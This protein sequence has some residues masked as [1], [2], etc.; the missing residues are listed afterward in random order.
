MKIKAFH[1]YLV[2]IFISLSVIATSIYYL[3]DGFDEI[4]VYELEGENRIV[5]GKHFIGKST[6]RTINKYFTESRKLI[7]DSAIIGTL[8]IV[9]NSNDSIQSNEVDYFV[10]I[11]IAGEMAEVPLG[12]QVRE[13]QCSKKLAVFLS[14][15]PWVRP[16]PRKINEL[17]DEKAVETK[18]VLTN[19]SFE[20]HYHDDS[21]SV[22]AWIY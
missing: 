12:Y 7:L 16:S 3:L 11:I 9:V 18:I 8:T 5:V 14:M 13:Y 2:T 10:G 15:H 4:V 20:L 6:D 22:E 1:I 19:Y 21:M 17:F